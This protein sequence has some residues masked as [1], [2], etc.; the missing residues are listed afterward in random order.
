M[1]IAERGKFEKQR[2]IQYHTKTGRRRK[3]EAT[4]EEEEGYEG[5]RKRR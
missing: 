3:G 5:M 1:R 4:A 2:K